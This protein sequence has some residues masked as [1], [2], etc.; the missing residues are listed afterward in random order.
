MRSGES[1]FC[2]RSA[3]LI[4]DSVSRTNR[5]GM[6]THQR[7]YEQ[8]SYMDKPT[9]GNFRFVALQSSD[10]MPLDVFG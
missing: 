7:K 5:F 3:T 4:E 9:C 10:K 2:S 8:I 1:D 6:A